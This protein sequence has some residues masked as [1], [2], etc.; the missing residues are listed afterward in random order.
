MSGRLDELVGQKEF[1]LRELHHRV[2]NSLNILTSMMT[3]QAKHARG[4]E[5]KEQLARAQSRILSMAAVY[6][7]LYR[8]ESAGEVDLS[9]FLQ[10]VCTEAAAAYNPYGAGA[11]HF[12]V[13]PIKASVQIASSIAL[14]LHELITNTMKHAYPAEQGGPIYVSCKRLDDTTAELRYSDRGVGLPPEVTSGDSA[15]L[16]MRLIKAT[17]R[18]LGGELAIARL[19]PGTEFITRIKLADAK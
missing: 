14:L 9:S 11:L 8:I 6:K 5:A 2:M 1:L 3:L 12:D 16:G 4:I 18:Q 17:A 7:F 10:T 13:D 19:E 15:S